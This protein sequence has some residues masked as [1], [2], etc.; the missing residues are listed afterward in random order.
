MVQTYRVS[1]I[2]LVVTSSRGS[3]F[4]P[5]WSR[6]EPSA[7]APAQF[8]WSGVG[9]VSAHPV[10]PFAWLPLVLIRAVPLQLGPTATHQKR[11]LFAAHRLDQG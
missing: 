9:V 1:S 8:S 6:A 4:S 7:C 10:Q 3:L 2:R 5:V 11:A